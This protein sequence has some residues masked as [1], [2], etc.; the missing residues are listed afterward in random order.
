M[1]IFTYLNTTDVFNL[2]KT[3]VHCVATWLVGVNSL[4]EGE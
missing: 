3:R 4:E 1:S 2:C